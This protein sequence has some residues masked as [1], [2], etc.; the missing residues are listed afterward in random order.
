[1]ANATWTSSDT[2]VA[3]VDSNGLVTGVNAGTT[4]ITAKVDTVTSAPLA[5]TVTAA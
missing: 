3:T 2:S 4:N 5:L 1:M